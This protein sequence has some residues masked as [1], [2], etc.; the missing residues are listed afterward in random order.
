MVREGHVLA[1]FN[2]SHRV[3]KAEGILKALGL[4]I[5]LVPAPRQLQTDCGL[6]LRFGA[7]AT[8]QVMQVLRQE[9]L[10]PAF[11]SEFRGGRFVTVYECEAG[12]INHGTRGVGA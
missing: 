2:S 9:K 1:V 4:T 5:L 11:A 6:A 8:E 12:I 3:M 7:D 10:L